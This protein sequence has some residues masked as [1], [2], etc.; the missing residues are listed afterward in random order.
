MVAAFFGFFFLGSLDLERVLR[1]GPMAIGL[2]FLPVAV[3][4][5]A[6]SLGISARLIMRFSSRR[7]LLAGPSFRSLLEDQIAVFVGRTEQA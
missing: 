1:Y 5:G 2:A 6:L 3:G 7:V 4:M